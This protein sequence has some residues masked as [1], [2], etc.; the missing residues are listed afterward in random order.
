MTRTSS[1]SSGSAPAPFAALPADRRDA[2]REAVDDV[3]DTLR[4]LPW[5]RTRDPW[6]ILVAETML[7]QTQV[8]R[9]IP[10]WE[11]FLDTWPDPDACAAAP[12]ADVIAAWDGL[13]YN[14][15]AV[16]LHAAAT[17]VASHHGGIVPDELTDLLAL[18][19]VGPYTARAVAVFAFERSEAVVD[20]NVARVLSRAVAGEPLGSRQLQELADE[21]VP[22]TSP[23]RHNQA[24][25][26]VGA[27]TCTKR[28]PDCSACRLS[29]VCA[30]QA[31]GGADAVPDPA[32]TTA[33]VANRQSTFAGSDRQGRGRLVT[34]LRRGPVAEA[35]VADLVGWD[36]DERVGRMVAG[37]VSDGLAEHRNGRLHLPS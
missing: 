2:V 7:Q 33:G 32:V 12:V 18:P 4:D 13:G 1:T 21:L 15:R 29:H 16:N 28:K 9:V 19:G 22:A 24:I 20:S 8:T 10:R 36:D 26:E 35:D 17:V 31:A 34:A 6:S 5:R 3:A 37:L 23:W 27:L 14:R 25:M 30:W 11:G